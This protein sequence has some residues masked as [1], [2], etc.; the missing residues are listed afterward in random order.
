MA[1]L[2]DI[3]ELI[4]LSDRPCIAGTK[5]SI[6]QI[7]SLTHDG[8]SPQAIVDEYPQLSLAQ[9]HAALTYYYA[10]QATID[11]ALTQEQRLYDQ[12]AS[13]QAI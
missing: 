13:A 3:G 5:I 4:S 1:T 8:L 11:E 7:A 6:Q 9:T 12:M 2:V 10:N